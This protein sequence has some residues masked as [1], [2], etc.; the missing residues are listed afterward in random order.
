MAF[1][2]MIFISPYF[3]RVGYIYSI[4]IQKQISQPSFCKIYYCGTNALKTQLSSQI[5]VDGS[6]LIRVGDTYVMPPV[7]SV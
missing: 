4:Q 5:G 6:I 7:L 3:R 1:L 2:G